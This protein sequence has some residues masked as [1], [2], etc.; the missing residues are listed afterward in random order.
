[1]GPR[2]DPCGTPEVTDKG[3]DVEPN[4]VIHWYRLC[5]YD[6]SHVTGSPPKTTLM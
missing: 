4:I 2:I 1:M 3:L 5:R 6:S